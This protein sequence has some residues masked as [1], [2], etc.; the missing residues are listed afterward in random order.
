M[1]DLRWPKEYFEPESNINHL[2]AKKKSFSNLRSKQSEA[3]SS[4]SN[5]IMPNDQKPRETKS[6]SY[7][8]I[9]YETI[10]STKGSSIGKSDPPTE[11]EFIPKPLADTG[12]LDSQDRYLIE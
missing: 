5:S 1:K 4:A 7:I 11:L 9:S 3:G 10:L 12:V 2:L 6:T 8:Y